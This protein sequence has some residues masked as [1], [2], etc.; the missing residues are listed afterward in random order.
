MRARR[1]KGPVVLM[2]PCGAWR[3]VLRRAHCIQVLVAAPVLIGPN[4]LPRSVRA[5]AI[6]AFKRCYCELLVR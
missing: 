4:K 1:V 3:G 5:Q 6:P 2:P